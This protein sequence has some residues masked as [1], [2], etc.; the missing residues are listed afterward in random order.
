MYASCCIPSTPGIVF[1][2]LTWL[3]FTDIITFLWYIIWRAVSCSK[4]FIIFVSADIFIKTPMPVFYLDSIWILDSET[5]SE[6]SRT[7]KMDLSAK[8][9]WCLWTSLIFMIW[10]SLEYFYQ[11]LKWCKSHFNVSGIFL[12][13]NRFVYF[14]ISFPT[15]YV[16]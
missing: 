15:L 13:P 14:K 12:C 11:H 6:T 9:K 2:V 16:K 7:S 3:L 5:Y 1:D 10:L 8:K 4:I